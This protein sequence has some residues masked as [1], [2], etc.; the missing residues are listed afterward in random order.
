MAGALIDSGVS[1][2]EYAKGEISAEELRE[3]LENTTIKAATTVFYAKAATAILGKAATPFV[4][5]GIYTIASYVISCTREILKEAKLNA[6]E[7]DRLTAVLIDSTATIES[8]HEQL[9]HNIENCKEQQQ[10]IL[11]GF[12]NSFDY[13]LET[14]ENYDTAF[15]AIVSFA[16]ETGI[17]LQYTDFD[18]FKNM[19]LSDETLE[20]R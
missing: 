20:L 12:L 1:L 13:N 7:Y 17:A 16:N 15:Y 14:G 4:S 19:M 2:Y 5:M 18:D 8:Y 3:E 10:V 6:E 9:R 11:N